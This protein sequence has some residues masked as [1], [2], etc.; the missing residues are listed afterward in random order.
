MTPDNVERRR[1]TCP[2]CDPIRRRPQVVAETASFWVLADIQPLAPGHLLLVPK[3]HLPCFGALPEP[4]D[5]EL[6]AL[7]ASVARFL[8]EFPGVPLYFEHG[9]AGQTVPHAHLHAL[10]VPVR[11]GLSEHL[12]TLG[13]PVPIPDPAALRRLYARGGPYVLVDE[14]QAVAVATVALAPGYLQKWVRARL[15]VPPSA[16]DVSVLRAAWRIAE[17]PR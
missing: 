6:A 13:A 7:R 12:S 2:F 1:D 15:P 5:A 9:V 3:D 16:P 14:G 4:L 10:C 11:P 17:R 8:A